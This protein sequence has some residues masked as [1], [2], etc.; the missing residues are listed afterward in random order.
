MTPDTTTTAAHAQTVKVAVDYGHNQW[1]ECARKLAA[2]ARLIGTTGTEDI[3]VIRAAALAV[4]EF[5]RL[6]AQKP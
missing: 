6:D 5:N 1:R 3:S 4:E 2:C